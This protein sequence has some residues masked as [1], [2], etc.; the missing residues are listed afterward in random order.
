MYIFDVVRKAYYQFIL[1]F[2]RN[3]K[4]RFFGAKVGRNVKFYGNP[5]VMGYYTRLTIGDGCFV[6]EGV[7]FNSRDEIKIGNHVHL[8]SYCKI[9]T[10]TIDYQD[11]K[12]HLSAPVSIGNNCAIASG[13]IIVGGVDICDDVLVA[14]GSVVTKSI[15]KPGLY[16]GN[17]ARF[18]R[19]HR[20]GNPDHYIE[21][22]HNDKKI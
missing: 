6:N 11:W 9:Y 3:L 15:D 1:G 13:A 8:S 18:I 17:P 20:V 22:R 4:F 12:T 2:W 7:V 10:G 14:A 16:A 21:Q 19:D 5:F